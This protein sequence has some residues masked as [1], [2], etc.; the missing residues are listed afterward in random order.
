M[1]EQRIQSTNQYQLFG[2]ISS[3]RK[4]DRQHVK[5]LAEAI[6]YNNLLHLNP[7]IVNASMQVI[8]GQHRLAAAKMLKIPIYYVQDEK[9]TKGQIAALNTNQKNWSTMDYVNYWTVE[10]RDGFKELTKFIEDSG[11]PVSAAVNLMA[12]D[13]KGALKDMREGWMDIGNMDMAYKIANFMKN[14]AEL[15][16]YGWFING[17]VAKALRRMWEHPDFKPE[18]F[19]E[20]IAFQPRSVVPCTSDKN[21]LAM[22]SEIYNWKLR[23]RVDFLSKRR[24]E[25]TK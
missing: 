10:K 16:N 9:V 21:Y 2:T 12:E 13:T 4:V 22:F 17:G 24:E 25:Q 8:D 20:K 23:Y 14:V 11:L 15:Y 7:I 18:E 6:E 19:A 3:N 1:K 5:R